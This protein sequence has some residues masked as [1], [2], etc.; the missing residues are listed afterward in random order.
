MIDVLLFFLHLAI[1]HCWDYEEDYLGV[2]KVGPG[3]PSKSV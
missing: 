2:A 1:Y 3:E